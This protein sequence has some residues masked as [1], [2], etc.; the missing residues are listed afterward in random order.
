MKEIRKK[1]RREIEN[2]IKRE[3]IKEGESERKMDEKKKDIIKVSDLCIVFSY[4][5]KKI[6]NRKES[7]K[8]ILSY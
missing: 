7:H 1:I 2:D 8:S 4:M 3:K 5:R 6:V